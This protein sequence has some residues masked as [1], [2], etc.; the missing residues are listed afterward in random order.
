MRSGQATGLSPSKYVCN[1]GVAPRWLLAVSF[2]HRTG[3]AGREL[4]QR[5]PKSQV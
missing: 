3:I 1:P 4:S 5:R 2:R